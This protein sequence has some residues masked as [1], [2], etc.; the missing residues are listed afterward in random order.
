MQSKKEGYISSGNT[1]KQDLIG[2]KA[3]AATILK[4]SGKIEIEGE[5]W[6]AVASEGYLDINSEVKIIRHENAHFIVRKI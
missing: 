2:K 5:L 6:E 3:I 4:P 1:I